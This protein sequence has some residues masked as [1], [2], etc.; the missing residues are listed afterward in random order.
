MTNFRLEIQYDGKRYSGWQ[1]QGNTQHTIQGKIEQI[2][3]R[4]TGHAVEIHGAGR[5]DAGVHARA[6][7]A[8]VKIQTEL[9][10]QQVQAYLNAYLPG[11][12]AVT[13]CRI[14][15][16]R[17]HARLNA[18]GKHYCYRLCDGGVPD[19]FFRNIVCAWEHPL[20]ME[21]MRQAA[22]YLVGTHD[23][24]GFSSVNRRFKKSTVRTITSLEVTRHGQE[25]HVDI[26][27]TGFL[28]NMVRIIVGTLVEAGEGKRKP[29]SVLDILQSLDRQD[30]GITMPPQGLMLE[31]VFYEGYG[32]GVSGS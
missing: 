1:K 14:V 9:S 26:Q 25:I 10:P 31:A 28:Y 5:T 7:V 13:D 22:V 8:N 32:V 20:D 11:D 24:R 3:S 29:E 15:P 18:K 19:V 30:A 12:I 6:Q 4:M 23:F 2:L 16:E 21:A 27:G 17:F